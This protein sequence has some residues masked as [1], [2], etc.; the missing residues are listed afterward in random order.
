MSSLSH[1]PYIETV[2]YWRKATVVKGFK[3]RFLL[4]KLLEMYSFKKNAFPLPDIQT[5]QNDYMEF[6]SPIKNMI[7]ANSKIAVVVPCFIRSKDSLKQLQRLYESIKKQSC[8]PGLV[9]F[10]DD[11]SP[12]QYDEKDFDGVIFLRQESNSGPAMARNI[13]L[14]YALSLDAE[15]IAF[16][17]SD[18][19]LSEDWVSSIHQAYINNENAQILS[20]NTLSYGRTWFDKYHCINGTLNGRVFKG[21]DILLY[22]PT[23]NLAVTSQV[24]I[25]M[26]FDTAFPNAA[27]EDIDFCLQANRKGFRIFFCAEMEIQHDYGYDKSF[28]ENIKKF[29]NQFKRYA[30]GE[31]ILLQKNPSY[32]MFFEQTK[33]ISA[34]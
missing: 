8:M 1:S 25:S 10:V 30:E 19:V 16:T 21:K 18:C 6:A 33:E 26:K 22:G 2:N 31:K 23:A 28:F 29:R 24:G 13:G 5:A 32:Y 11:C 20:G 7:D 27:G 9:I 12:L 3:I 15:I 17:D 14:E 34:V 4:T